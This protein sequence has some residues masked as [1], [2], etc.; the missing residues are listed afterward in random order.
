M[1]TFDLIFVERLMNEY[2]L[3]VSR[4][5]YWKIGD[6]SIHTENFDCIL[7]APATCGVCDFYG[8]P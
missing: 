8:R 1:P 2:R 6:H 5:A 3:P 4:F 7:A